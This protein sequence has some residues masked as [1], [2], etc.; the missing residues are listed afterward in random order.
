MQP[1]ANPATGE[2]VGDTS[3]FEAEA[4]WLVA[5]GGFQA[6]VR[7]ITVRGTRFENIAFVHPLAEE[8]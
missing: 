8:P 5:A 3:Q 1:V 7:E 2:T 4:P 6:V